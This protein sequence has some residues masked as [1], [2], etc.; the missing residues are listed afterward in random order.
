VCSLCWLQ[1]SMVRCV[2][3]CVSAVLGWAPVEAVQRGA[4]AAAPKTPGAPLGESD[5]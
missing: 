2:L 4:A 5:L 3:W 1:S